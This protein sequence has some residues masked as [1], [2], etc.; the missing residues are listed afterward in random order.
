MPERG[1]SA[2]L[3]RHPGGS[4]SRCV[5]G[6]EAVSCQEL[7]AGAADS[8]RSSSSSGSCGAV[9]SGPACGAARAVAV[10]EAQPQ[11]RL[12]QLDGLAQRAQLPLPQRLL[13]VQG[14]ARGEP[15]GPASMCV[16]GRPGIIQS[17]TLRTPGAQECGAA[18]RRWRSVWCGARAGAAST[19]RTRRAAGSDRICCGTPA[20]L[21]A[22]SCASRSTAAR[23]SARRC[24]RGAALALT[25]SSAPCSSSSLRPSCAS[26]AERGR[27]L[28]R[29]VLRPSRHW[30]EQQ[31]RSCQGA[32]VCSASAWATSSAC[33]LSRALLLAA[34]QADPCDQGKPAHDIALG[35][36]L[37][38]PT[39]TTI[40]LQ[41][42]KVRIPQLFHAGHLGIRP[43]VHLILRAA[44]L[45]GQLI[46]I[47]TCH[48][49][50][51][52]GRQSH[53]G[54]TCTSSVLFFWPDQRAAAAAAGIDALCRPPS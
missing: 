26:P 49:P 24:G 39:R 42:V 37:T 19:A 30:G 53:T 32:R 33:C 16:L 41:P 5:G 11:A 15:P 20:S 18:Q 34:A 29:D 47:Y 3:L 50:S 46:Q 21:R 4:D 12:V 52:D 28:M 35:H 22:S 51:V 14:C 43:A 45:L 54:T 10:L 9:P 38:A 31:K 40:F 1:N 25:R 2:G 13:V 36:T 23:S 7:V 27:S 8:S 17:N 48:L 44:D 6:S